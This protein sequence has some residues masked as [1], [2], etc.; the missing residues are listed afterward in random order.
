M[1][2]I[3]RGLDVL[4]QLSMVVAGAGML[5]MM[6]L[7]VLDVTFKYVFHQPI[8]GTL[9]IVS[10]Y[11]MAACSFL[12]FAY[13]QK[14]E[15]HIVMTLAT[16]QMPAAALRILIVIV[17][18]FSAAY[19]ILFTYASG[20]AAMKMALVSESTTVINTEILIWPARWFVPVGAGLMACWMVLQALVVWFRSEHV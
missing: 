3:R 9:E 8:Q 5:A 1:L 7:V 6:L 20:V 14:L 18:L 15:G 2:I 19:L 17:Y 12:P 16:E 13:V 4:T 11:F 10:F